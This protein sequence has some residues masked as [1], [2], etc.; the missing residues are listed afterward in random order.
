[1]TSDNL[2][3]FEKFDRLWNLV[4]EHGH[5]FP[6]KDQV[7]KTIYEF[8]CIW[9]IQMHGGNETRILIQLRGGRLWASTNEEYLWFSVGNTTS[10]D[11]LY[12]TVFGNQI[13]Y[14]AWKA[15]E[16]RN[17][18]KFRNLPLYNKGK[19]LTK[20]E[21]LNRLMENDIFASITAYSKYLGK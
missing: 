18:V 12:D 4:K 10:L 5:I 21:L 8:A 20:V 14:E 17:E 9:A 19:A 1:M 16:L 2:N 15:K 11:Y 3:T 6:A 7:T 13:D